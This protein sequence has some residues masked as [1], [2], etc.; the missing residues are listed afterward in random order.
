MN[1]LIN[2]SALKKGGGQNVALNF[3][4]GLFELKYPTHTFFFLVVKHSAIHK[5]LQERKQQNIIFS[6]G[7][8]IK[9]IVQ[10][11]F[12]LPKTLNRLNIDITYTY[13]GYGLFN[14][15]IPQVSG[16]AVSNIFFPEIKFWEGSSLKLLMY[17]IIDRYR[18]YGIKKANALIFENQAMEERAHRIY[19]ILK[20]KTTYIAPSF[21]PTFEQQELKINGLKKDTT[22]LLMLCGWQ[23]NKNIM[24]VP[25]IASLL[26]QASEEFRF[27]ITAPEDNSTD[28]LEF[29]RLVE[30]YGV[31]EMISI[32]GPVSKQQLKSLYSQ[33]DFV[34]LMSKLESF[35]NNIIEAWYFKKPLIVSNEEWSKAI[36]KNAGYYVNRESSREVSDSIYQLYKSENI[37][38]QLI[39]S[40]LEN[41]KE[42]PSIKEKTSLEIEFLEK[43]YHDF[44]TTV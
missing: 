21:N 42:Y 12:K 31:K 22:K 27:I 35:S 3:L 2:F 19:K 30:K 39:Q 40:G 26:K 8:P 11:F 36:C 1:I 7:S 5:Y 28:H 32:I 41:L 37:Q 34:L 44:K 10:E 29:S 25:E 38:S 16:V 17:K 33:I 9:R 15:S 4:H 20:S 6:A 23:R 14:N 43:I 13:F 24:K 18:L